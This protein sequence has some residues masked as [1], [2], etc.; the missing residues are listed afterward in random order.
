MSYAKRTFRGMLLLPVLAA[1]GLMLAHA[2]VEDG[3][4]AGWETREK[5]AIVGP[6]D[7]IPARP[8]NWHTTLTGTVCGA[9]FPACPPD[10]IRVECRDSCRVVLYL[11][12]EAWE[13]VLPRKDGQ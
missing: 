10:S 1:I 6:Q 5:L 4:G 8:V 13:V 11:A 12:G 7:T 9:Y 3:F 2:L